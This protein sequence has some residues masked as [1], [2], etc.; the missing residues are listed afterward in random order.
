MIATISQTTSYEQQL[1]SVIKRLPPHCVSQVIDFAK[2]LEFQ[3]I[4]NKNDSLTDETEEEITEHDTRWDELLA[5]DESQ[6]LLEKMADEA[7][8][9]I[10]A[11]RA[12]PIAFT[13][14]GRICP[15]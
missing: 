9:D 3:L 13:D 1:F 8:A 4:G 12:R 10:H 7:L 11:G 15:G 14:D 5:T 2:F 6:R